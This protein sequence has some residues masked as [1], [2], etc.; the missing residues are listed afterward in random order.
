MSWH[1]SRALV[2]EY[3][4]ATCS[5]GVQSA[6]LS[7][8]PTPQ[9]YL[10]KDRMTAFSRLSRFGMTFAPLTEPLGVELLMWFQG[11]SRVRTYQLPGMAPELTASALACGEKWRESSVRY[12]LDSSSWRIH[13]SLFPEDLPWSSVTLPKWGMTRSGAVYQ[14]PTQERPISAT[15][16]GL[17]PTPRAGNPGSRPNGKGGKILEEEVLISVGIRSRGMYMKDPIRMWPTPVATM[18]KGSSPASLTRANGKDRSNDH[19]DHA[20]MAEEGGQL[21]PTWVEW[22]MG[23]PLG[24]TDLKPLEMDRFREWQRQHSL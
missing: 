16:S 10:C 20:I 12:D 4:V 8:N 6:Q 14:H 11:D 24:W 1:Y 19:L 23:W 2:E 13:L 9:A 15:V 21:N 3:S 17:W 18:S 22:L 7:A 5:D